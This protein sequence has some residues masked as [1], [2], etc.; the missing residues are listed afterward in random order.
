MSGNLNT[1]HT[2]TFLA[3]KFRSNVITLGDHS[4]LEGIETLSSWKETKLKFF[5]SNDGLIFRTIF[6][7][8]GKEVSVKDVKANRYIPFNSRVTRG[9]KFIEIE[10]D[11]VNNDETLKL[12]IRHDT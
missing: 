6:D 2:A 12:V 8:Y 4:V 3:G 11:S 9:I 10:R 1:I 5:A 7:V